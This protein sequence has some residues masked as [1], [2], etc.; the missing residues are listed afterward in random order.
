STAARRRTLKNENEPEASATDEGSV[1]DASGSS[2]H[3]GDAQQ[4]KQGSVA[5]ASGS[6]LRGGGAP[7]QREESV[8]NAS[9]ASARP[10]FRPL[11]GL[12]HLLGGSANRQ[13]AVQFLGLDQDLDDR[14][15]RLAE[16]AQGLDRG[17][18]GSAVAPQCRRRLARLLALNFS[19]QSLQEQR[20]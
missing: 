17:H 8:A 3:G 9:G 13:V 16:A 12:Q 18:P 6:L 1:A 11:G 15:V 4:L 5:D 20:P 19:G 7:P 2:L 10:A 14:C